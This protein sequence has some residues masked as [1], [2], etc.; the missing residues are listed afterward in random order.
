MDGT[1][2]QDAVMTR[3]EHV[4][5]QQ[6]L[7]EPRA[8]L[9]GL[10][11]VGAALRVPETVFVGIGLSSPRELSRA[12]PVDALGM[13]FAAEQ[14]RRA[15]GA[16]TMT[17]LIA[18]AHALTNG[19]SPDVVAA[20]TEAHQ[21]TLGRVLDR[22]AWS[23][24]QVV[25]AREL[26]ALESHARV[27]AEIRRAAPNDEHPYVTRELADIE[28]F[29]R[30]G[31]GVLKVGWA[32]GAS[33]PSA[34]DERAFDERFRR[35]VGSHV[36]FVYCKAGR[37]LDDRRRKAPPYLVRDPSRRVCLSPGERVREKLARASGQVSSST[38]RGVRRHLKAITRCYKQLVRPL[39]G[40][41]ED[42]V[43]TLLEQLLGPEGLP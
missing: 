32:L 12:L 41:I 4:V 1:R 16:G 5:L 2:T 19:H 15:V 39:D 23:H 9:A 43:Q 42:Q 13:L 21:R 14:A 40:Q 25:R 38:L 33:S 27:H 30:T 36:P 18:D 11:H 37:T 35:W 7:F 17:V 3:L 28:Y 24:V 26:H 34:R 29:A 10:A 31:G 22:L 8:S 6:A 20:C